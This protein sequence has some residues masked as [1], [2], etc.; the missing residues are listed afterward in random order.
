MTRICIFDPGIE[1]NQG[2]LSSN[3]GD[4]V[5]Q[6]AVTRE[7]GALFG[8][9]SLLRISTQVAMQGDELRAA[10]ACD[11]RF[12]GGTNLLSSRMRQYRQW[13]ISLMD[14]WR[15]NDAVL[16][17]VGWWGYQE[18]P[19]FYTKLVLRSALSKSGLHSV[20]DG[21][22]LE[23]L[24]AAGFQNVI[25]TGCPT[26]W[27]LAELDPA[28]IPSTKSDAVLMMLTDY[29][30]EP[31]LDRRLFELLRKKYGTV[32]LWP[33][34]RADVEYVR[35]LA[36][37]VTMLGHS[38]TALDDLLRSAP[39]LD[40]VGTR[41]HGGVHCLLAHRRALVLEVD[42]RAREIARDTGLPTA[43][44]SDFEGIERWIDGPTTLNLKM[45]VAAIAEWR[46]QWSRG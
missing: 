25:N 39:S 7:L 23:K 5:I 28:T 43:A 37:P 41:L 34:G 4:L 18:N 26:M 6:D 27:P 31:E 17:G 16:L 1:N 40:Y 44:R 11:H 32:Y 13:E 21:Y 2:S 29:R 42:N 10:L 24:R 22:S 36:L 38:L 15:I 12:V 19:D 20:R 33:Q 46:S 45:N 3:L 14:A 9:A 35:T 8:G 30:T